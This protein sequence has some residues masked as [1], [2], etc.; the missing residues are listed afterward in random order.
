[1]LSKQFVNTVQDKQ[2]QVIRQIQKQ[3]EK[4]AACVCWMLVFCTAALAGQ[5]CAADSV[6]ATPQTRTVSSQLPLT[7]V[8]PSENTTGMTE[9]LWPYS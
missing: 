5:D 2:R 8:L 6:A 1:M 4:F 3:K 7:I 9:S